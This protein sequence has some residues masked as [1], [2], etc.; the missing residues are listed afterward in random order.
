MVGSYSVLHH[1]PDYLNTIDEF[2]RIVRP[3]GIIYVDHEVSPSYWEMSE[4]Y[5]AYLKDLGG[6]FLQD[7]LYE[8]DMV[9]PEPQMS[10]T[11]FSKRWFSHLFNRNKEGITRVVGDYGDIHVFMH[12]HIEWENIASH[13]SKG[14][15]VIA[16]EDY[17]VCRERTDDPVIWQKWRHKCSDMRYMIFRKRS[18]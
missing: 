13:M 17:L 4:T 6:R 9:V 11:F 18:A 3:G 10:N 2:V 16:K 14:C 7:H 8:L 15:D 1:V 5:N 12:D